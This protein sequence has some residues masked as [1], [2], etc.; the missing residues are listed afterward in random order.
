MQIATEIGIKIYAPGN[1]RN[2]AK[3]S[4]KCPE[5]KVVVAKLLLESKLECNKKA[6]KE[7]IHRSIPCK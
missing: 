7:E 5:E 1:K 4:V 3:D 2:M 6:H